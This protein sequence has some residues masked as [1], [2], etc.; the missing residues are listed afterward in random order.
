MTL[1]LILFMFGL[2]GTV[3]SDDDSRWLVGYGISLL[4][5]FL[6]LAMTANMGV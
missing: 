1:G 3:V 6:L 5:G 2:I 4:A